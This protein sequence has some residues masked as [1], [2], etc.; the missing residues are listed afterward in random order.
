MATGLAVARALGDHF[1]KQRNMGMSGEP[2]V[3][4]P[5][6]IEAEDHMLIVASDGVRFVESTERERERMIYVCV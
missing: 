2:F 3:S 1:V 6:K 5:Y 4:E